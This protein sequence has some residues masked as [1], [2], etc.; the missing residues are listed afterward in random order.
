MSTGEFL[1]LEEDS[2]EYT[3]F[4]LKGYEVIEVIPAI[5]RR[6]ARITYIDKQ[7]LLKLQELKVVS[8]SKSAIQIDFDR[9]FKIL[10]LFRELKAV[11]KQLKPLIELIK[12]AKPRDI[13]TEWK[14]NIPALTELLRLHLKNQKLEKTLRLK[15]LEKLL[16]SD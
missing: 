2:D 16:E 10:K 7:Y 14:L 12:Q 9:F 15:E 1:C 5:G 13:K 6:R 8:K 4:T 11:P 3:D